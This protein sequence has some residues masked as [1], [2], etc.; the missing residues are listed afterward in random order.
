M[1]EA[2]LMN[3]FQK[4]LI[5]TA[6]PS[7]LIEIIDAAREKR[8]ELAINHHR[9]ILA[10]IKAAEKDGFDVVVWKRDLDEYINIGVNTE[11]EVY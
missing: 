4:I 1:K 11:I 8:N 10:A 5:D 7:E 2:N 6:T 3:E 9:A